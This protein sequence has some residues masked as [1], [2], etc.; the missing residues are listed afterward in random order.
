MLRIVVGW[1]VGLRA[2]TDYGAVGEAG[3]F[4]KC[5]GGCDEEDIGVS[6]VGSMGDG[7]TRQGKRETYRR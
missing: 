7:K 2:E 4:A 1:V 3:A 6:K 5:W